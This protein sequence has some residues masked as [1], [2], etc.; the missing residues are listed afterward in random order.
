M[1]VRFS[2]DASERERASKK[3]VLFCAYLYSAMNVRVP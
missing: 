1:R 2:L 3:S